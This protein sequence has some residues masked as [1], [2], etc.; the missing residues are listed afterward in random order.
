M[1]LDWE[2]DADKLNLWGASTD[3][4]YQRLEIILVP[5]NYMHTE[6][7]YTGDSIAEGCIADE[8]AQR[9]YLDSFYLALYLSD[10]TFV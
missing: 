6:L 1:C 9:D 2:R 8:Q 5:C 10:Q 3:A 7:G 4:F